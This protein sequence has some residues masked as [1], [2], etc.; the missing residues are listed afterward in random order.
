MSKCPEQVSENAKITHL[1]CPK[2]FSEPG[3]V[4]FYVLTQVLSKKKKKF[5]QLFSGHT[6]SIWSIW[7]FGPQNRAPK[8]RFAKIVK[9]RKIVLKSTIIDRF[10]FCKKIMKFWGN[11]EY[12]QL[13]E[14]QKKF[15]RDFYTQNTIFSLFSMQNH[16]FSN[17]QN[18]VRVSKKSTFSQNRV[19]TFLLY[20]GHPWTTCDPQKMFRAL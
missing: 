13:T 3:K 20:S 16:R 17:R 6:D 5:F 19:Y 12:I 2:H 15:F 8:S 9:N 14:G 18:G 10:F 11:S 1:Q 4:V 7:N